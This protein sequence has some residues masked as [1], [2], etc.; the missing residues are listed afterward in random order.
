MHARPKYR[1]LYSFTVHTLTCM[2]AGSKDMAACRI[3]YMVD[4]SAILHP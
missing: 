1:V 2:H 3:K 4:D